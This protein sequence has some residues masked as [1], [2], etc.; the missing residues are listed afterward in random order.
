LKKSKQSGGWATKSSQYLFESQWY[1]LKQDQVILPNGNQITY[2]SIEHPGYV[3]VVPLFENK[4]V[5]LE[6]IF[7]YTIEETILEFPSGGLDGETPVVA[8]NRELQE[9][10]GWIA[11]ELMHLGEYFGSSGISDEKYNIYLGTSL[12]NLE[13]MKREPTEQIELER[14]S[15]NKL[16]SMVYSGE[17]KDGPTCLAALLTM[18]YTNNKV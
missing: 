5:L 12:K 13:N 1:D 6:R 17:L 15:L 7:R 8:A 9:E 3:I 18:Q 4:D 2:T 14:I 11:E 10:T 16:V